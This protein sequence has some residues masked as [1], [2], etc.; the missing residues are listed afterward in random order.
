MQIE[1]VTFQGH[2]GTA[3]AARLD[4]PDGPVRTSA[5]LAHCF[6]CSKDVT[7]AKRIAGSLAAR[8][9]AVLRFD[10]TGLGHSEGEFANTNFSSNVEDLVLAARYLEARGMPPQLM[11]GHSLGGAAVLKAAPQVASLKAVVTIGAPADPAHV[12]HNFGGKLDAI[13]QTGSAM[14]ELAGR[15]FEIRRHFIEDIEAASLTQALGHL[16][17]ALL[18]LHAPRD[19]IVGIDNAAT[20]FKA[21]R[22][23]KSFVTLDDADHMITRAE[24]ADYVA[25]V[26]VAW[27]RRYLDLEPLPVVPGAPDGVVRV[28]EVAP[29][30]FRQDVIIGDRHHFI[31]DEP[32][33]MGGSDLGPSPYQ[34]VAAGLGACTTITLRMY[35]R[36]KGIALAG[37]SV[38]VLHDKR[39]A[40][41]CADCE[42]PSQKIDHFRREIRLSGDLTGAER[43]LLLAIADKCPVHR[44]LHGQ[45]EIETVLV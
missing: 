41:A 27:S 1:R 35:A 22:H 11:I 40:A 24:D 12:A 21:A 4:L 39:H 7:A 16:H 36:R 14:V 42:K 17:K 2:A 45:A 28:R 9:I 30:G 33:D 10:F 6:T 20:I 29:D 44:T 31:V 43:D 32:V 18:V 38:D 25:E 5:I 19:E 15:S 3:L 34:L 8:G 23:P 37:I 26:I 13:R